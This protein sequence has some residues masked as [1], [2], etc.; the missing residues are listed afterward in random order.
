MR[1]KYDG[2][3]VAVKFIERGVKVGAI[4]ALLQWAALHEM[5]SVE[6]GGGQ[7]RAGQKVME[8]DAAV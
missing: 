5:R 7:S 6:E 3:L 1:D 2:E 4:S 8:A